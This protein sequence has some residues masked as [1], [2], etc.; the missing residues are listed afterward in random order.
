MHV[1]WRQ[2]SKIKVFLSEIRLTIGYTESNRFPRGGWIL[3][4]LHASL[5]YQRGIS[6]NDLAMYLTTQRECDNGMRHS[7]AAK[8]FCLPAL[9]PSTQEIGAL[10]SS[11]DSIIALLTQY[12]NII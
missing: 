6:L 12:K 11:G 2:S 8:D 10:S 7:S 3:G 1:G 5:A 9:L 4:Y